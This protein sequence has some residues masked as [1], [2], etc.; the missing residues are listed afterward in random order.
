MMRPGTKWIVN[1]LAVAS[2]ILAAIATESPAQAI[3]AL[4]GDVGGVHDPAVIK[5]GNTFY[6]FFTGGRAGQGVIPV[7]TSTNGA[8]PS[9]VRY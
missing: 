9:V 6:V 8:L 1:T 4:D 3:L 7:L 2:A 5:D